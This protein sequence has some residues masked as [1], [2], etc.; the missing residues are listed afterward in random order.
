MTTKILIV[1][2]IVSNCL[3]SNAQIEQVARQLSEDEYKRFAEAL[4]NAFEKGNTGIFG[5]SRALK[6][7]FFLE[8]NAQTFYDFLGWNTKKYS[9]R[10]LGNVFKALSDNS[11][12]GKNN[13]VPVSVRFD[14]PAQPVECIVTIKEDKRGTPQ[15]VRRETVINY[16][17]T[18]KTDVEVEVSKQGVE[19]SNVFNQII[20]VWDVKISLVN[21]EVNNRRK[22]APP[23]L[24]TIIIGS[25]IDITKPSVEQMPAS[26]EKLIDEDEEL[27]DE[28]LVEELIDVELV[29]EFDDNYA[30]TPDIASDFDSFAETTPEPEVDEIQPIQF[31]AQPVQP[32]MQPVQPDVQPSFSS[33]GTHYR[34]QILSNTSYV[35]PSQLHQRFRVDNLMV[36]K[37]SDNDFKY[38]VPANTHSEA[39][40]IRNM[41]A[42]RGVDAWIATYENGE[43][44]RP[45]LGR[46]VIVSL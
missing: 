14:F 7:Q 29:E 36:E 43:R 2:L 12:H 39:V 18:T 23:I 31:I 41:M 13:P 17:V 28:E 45:A 9:Q 20:M 33:S 40:A 30:I 46:P 4:P 21:G 42:E 5:H 11:K 38:V 37:Y 27:I 32:D 6:R 44:V 22:I 35:P 19:S 24:R 26:A 25:E 1:A 10:S 8:E 34:V 16:V 3:T 15:N